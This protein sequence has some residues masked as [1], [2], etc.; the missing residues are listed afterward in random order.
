M[1]YA[2]AVSEGVDTAAL[3]ANTAATWAQ[4]V[5]NIALKTSMSPLPIITLSLIA[6]MG[7][8]VATIAGIVAIFKEFKNNSPEGKL[9]KSTAA[10]KAL[11]EKLDEAKQS[12]ENLKSAF[13]NYDSVVE[14]LENCTRGTDEWKQALEDVNNQVL[15]IINKYPELLE[16]E[17][18]ITRKD[19]VLSISEDARQRI[20]DIADS[21]VDVLQAASLQMN[22]EVKQNKLAVDVIDFGKSH[23]YEA[24]S[25][26]DTIM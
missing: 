6:A 8:L 17:G 19:G 21:R 22:N 25:G 7:L 18:A 9:A 4:V 5:A 14:K 12:A 20:Q 13:D 23:T 26:K 16:M 24:G 15:D 10:A 1:T 2:K 3:G 11:S